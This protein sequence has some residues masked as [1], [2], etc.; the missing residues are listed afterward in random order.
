MERIG[1]VVETSLEVPSFLHKHSYTKKDGLRV[2]TL[3]NKKIGLAVSGIGH[4]RVK[5]I[6]KNLI[7]SF[8]P[9]YILF[10]GYCGAVNPALRLKDIV[11]AKRVMYKSKIP[12]VTDHRL[13]KNAEK[14]LESYGITY[15]TGT[16]QTFDGVAISRKSVLNGVDAVDME[17]YFVMEKALEDDVPI[18]IVKSVSDIIPKYTPKFYPKK[19]IKLLTILKILLGMKRGKPALDNFCKSLIS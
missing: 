5:K 1:L 15:M 18:V 19:V 8:F 6:V 9:D 3:N 4:M 11:V 14:I 17:S 10:I 16:L 2:Y 12:L 13:I 7:N